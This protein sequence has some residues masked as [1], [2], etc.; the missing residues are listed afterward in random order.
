[1]EDVRW[2]ER[3]ISDFA[4]E[5]WRAKQISRE[6]Q[7][8]RNDLHLQ[9][10]DEASREL[11][12][13]YL[14]PHEDESNEM[15]QALQEQIVVL[16]QICQLLESIYKKSI[17]VNQLSLEISI[18]LLDAINEI[19]RAYSHYDV[20]KNNYSIAKSILPKIYDSI[21]NANCMEKNRVHPTI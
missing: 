14:N 8:Y 9:W 12:G 11:N 20:Y 3:L 21:D 2:Y 13:R 6:L 15:F 16:N 1:M 18:I 10:N 17:E 19:N 5:R 4:E 7:E